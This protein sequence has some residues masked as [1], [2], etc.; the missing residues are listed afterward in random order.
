M[1]LLSDVANALQDA[2]LACALIGA[3]AMAA[4]GIARSTMDLDLLIVDTM[5][6]E[7]AAW[8]KLRR[9]G[10]ILD[11]R[12]G[13]VEDPLAGVVRVQREGE[14]PV[15]VVVGRA[16]WQRRA[17]ERA[18]CVELD[19]ARIPIVLPVDLVLLKLYAGSPKDLWDIQGLLALPGGPRLRDQVEAALVDLPLECRGKW[20][21]ALRMA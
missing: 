11:I 12:R 16:A 15:D 19:G 10:M 18:T 9:S 21:S 3:G 13:D 2:G 8:E 1:S 20:R 17:I 4:H 14:S 5:A 7:S 6:F